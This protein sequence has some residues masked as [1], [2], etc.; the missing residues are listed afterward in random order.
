MATLT[1]H[2]AEVTALAFAPGGKLLATGDD[3][4]DCRLWRFDPAANE[5]QG[6]EW[7]RGHSR[8]I[9]AMTFADDGARLITS[10]GDN[11]CGQW[12]VVA[13]KEI[14]AGV[15]KHPEWVTDIVVSDDG[16]T[17]PHF[18]RRRQAAT[19]V[20][21][22]RQAPADD[23]IAADG[24]SRDCSRIRRGRQDG[25]GLHVDRH[26]ERRSARAD[27]VRRRRNCTALEPRRRRRTR[28]QR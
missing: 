7:L 17:A 25:D 14:R 24:V 15:L 3:R 23:G 19:L 5:W 21:R 26:V 10:S 1:G 18:L 9:T 2:E 12:D 20:A 13:G 8:T 6:G 4:G 11:T 27:G 16:R 22:R 28:R